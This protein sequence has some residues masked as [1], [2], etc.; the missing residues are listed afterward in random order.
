MS[1]M[2]ATQPPC[3]SGWLTIW[4]QRPSAEFASRRGDFA[5]C[6]LALDIVVELV[7]VAL[8]RACRGAMMHDGAGVGAGF[9]DVRS[10]GRTCR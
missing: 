1:S 2:V 10:T 5:L 7:R 8:E 3:D 6:D 4:N 9:D